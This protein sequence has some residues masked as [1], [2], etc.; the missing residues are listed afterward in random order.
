M[1]TYN[2]PNATKVIVST[3]LKWPNPGIPQTILVIEANIPFSEN[4]AG[5]DA[6]KVGSLIDF[7]LDTME[8][9]QTE[10]AEIHPLSEPNVSYMV[11]RNQ[12]THA[13][14]PPRDPS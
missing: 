2:Q 7:A 12:A 13:P 11:P 9:L 10:M 4:A 6:A 1:K 8:E 14:R 5:Y 3:R